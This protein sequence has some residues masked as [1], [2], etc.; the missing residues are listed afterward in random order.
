M[1]SGAVLV[2]LMSSFRPE[3]WMKGRKVSAVPLQARCPLH[4]IG[5]KGSELK[6]RGIQPS[7]QELRDMM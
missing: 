4:G 1:S 3:I 5:T 6:R 7:G 2:A